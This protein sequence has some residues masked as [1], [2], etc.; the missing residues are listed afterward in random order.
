[1][2]GDLPFVRGRPVHETPEFAQQ[3]RSA[4]LIVIGI[5]VL[6][7]AGGAALLYFGWNDIQAAKTGPTPVTAEQLK[8]AKSLDA[9][10]AEWVTLTPTKVQDTLVR[11]QLKARN[12]APGPKLEYAL[13]QIDDRYLIAEM[14]T[15]M[16]GTAPLN[17]R[18]YDLSTS[19]VVAEIESKFPACKGNLLPFELVT[20][21]DQESEAQWIWIGA[22]VC[23]LLGLLLIGGGIAEIGRAH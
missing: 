8:A 6:A 11:R 18:L 9:L 20:H 22:G 3:R 2:P 23:G 17:G 1:M 5:G 14:Y 10:P 4:N 16:P 12:G 15:V 7:L 13:V 19:D 21:K